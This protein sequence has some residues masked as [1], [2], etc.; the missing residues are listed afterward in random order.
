M[1]WV[2][3]ASE[4]RCPSSFE[5]SRCLRWFALVLFVFDDFGS[6][7]TGRSQ[8]CPKFTLRVLKKVRGFH[9]LL[10]KCG[11]IAT[12]SPLIICHEWLKEKSLSGRCL[13]DKALT[14]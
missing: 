3:E 6:K 13:L 7:P 11:N 12:T 2:K 8:N 5:F 10:E 9:F 14:F 4:V 1:N